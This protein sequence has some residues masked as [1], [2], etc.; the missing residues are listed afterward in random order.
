M[1]IIQIQ[2][3]AGLHL[4]ETPL[5][6]VGYISSIG[7]KGVMSW[8]TLW[9]FISFLSDIFIFRKKGCSTGRFCGC[10][11]ILDHRADVSHRCDTHILSWYQRSLKKKEYVHHWAG[12]SNDQCHQ[13]VTL[14]SM[15][16]IKKLPQPLKSLQKGT[17]CSL[18]FHGLRPD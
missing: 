3:S 15:R 7:K 4:D 17:K 12:F 18:W 2:I 8:S 5:D 1:P 16:D 13:A 14:L 10:L 6:L 11:Y 9:P